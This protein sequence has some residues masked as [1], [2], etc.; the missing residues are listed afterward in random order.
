MRDRA[1]HLLLSCNVMNYESHMS[2]K[3]S[4]SMFIVS[5]MTGHNFS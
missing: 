3:L 1:V 2:L 4:L 5:S